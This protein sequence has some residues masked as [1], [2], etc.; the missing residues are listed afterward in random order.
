MRTLNKTL[1][2]VLA[3]V[4]VL[5]MFG[6]ASAA[7][8]TDD[9]TIQY[10]EAVGVM[11]GIEAINGMGDGTF[12]PKSTATRAQVAQIYMNAMEIL[13]KTVDR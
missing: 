12:Q 6:V 3:L 8:F 10:K 4:M 9:E 11:T 2:L 5:G 1:A 7:D 13:N